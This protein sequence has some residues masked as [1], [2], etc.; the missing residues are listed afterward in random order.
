MRHASIDAESQGA[1]PIEFLPSGMVV[2]VATC[3][4][5]FKLWR[6]S[7]ILDTY[8]GKAV[9][10]YNGEPLFA[11]LAILRL[12]QEGGWQGVWIDTFRQKFRQSL[13]PH[14]CD[15]PP[16]AQSFLDQANQGR[17]W[18]S[19]CSDVLAWDDGRYLFVEAKHKGKDRIRKTQREW[20]E[21]ALNS[22]VPL[23]SFLIFEWSISDARPTSD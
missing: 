19:G 7:P 18:R 21:S 6:G 13:P 9:L 23:E 14:S 16:R 10:D 20:L 15:L 11:E 12:I 8:G 5:H 17:K 4:R 3:F 1:S 22:G 2:P